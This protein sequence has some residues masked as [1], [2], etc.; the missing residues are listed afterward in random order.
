MVFLMFTLLIKPINKSDA[1]KVNSMAKLI[2]IIKGTSGI[3]M[4]LNKIPILAAS[5]VPAV[6]G[7]TNLFCDKC[8]NTKPAKLRPAP[9]NRRAKVRGILLMI[10]NKA[11]SLLLNKLAKLMSLMPVKRDI[12]IRSKSR[13]MAA[14]VII[15]L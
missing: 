3:K 5:K 7:E 1:K 8:W 9:T 15:N 12:Q 6:V 13:P 2:F 10:K 11:C 4:M 14:P